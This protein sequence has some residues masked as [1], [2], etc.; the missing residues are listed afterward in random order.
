MRRIYGDKRD[1]RKMGWYNNY[2][3]DLRGMHKSRRAV[4]C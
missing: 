3:I 4:Y 2:R 1:L